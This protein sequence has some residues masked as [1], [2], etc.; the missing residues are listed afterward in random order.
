MSATWSGVT[1]L[2]EILRVTLNPHGH[3][4]LRY[5]KTLRYSSG[6]ILALMVLAGTVA[7]TS[8][9]TSSSANSLHD[10]FNAEREERG[11]APLTHSAGLDALAWQQLHGILAERQ[12]APALGRDVTAQIKLAELVAAAVQEPDGWSYRHN[13]LVVSYG[14]G[15]ERT[16]ND[17]FE[18]YANRTVLFDPIMDV[19]G[20]AI[21]EVPPGPPW[22]APPVGGSGPDVELT[23]YSMVVIVLA[24]DF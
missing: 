6:F 8:P 22:L 12:L 17:A 20:I 14:V 10:Q 18:V 16:L 24:G 23:G 5:W 21:A 7:Q 4:R 2:R 9:P 15:I 1:W 11:L 3:R 13:G 19:V